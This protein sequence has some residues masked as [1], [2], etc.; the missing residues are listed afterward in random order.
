M[1]VWVNVGGVRSR[2]YLRRWWFIDTAKCCRGTVRSH[3]RVFALLRVSLRKLVNFRRW[4]VVSPTRWL[5]WRPS[6]GNNR[7]AH[8][9]ILATRPSLFRDS[10]LFSVRQ[11]YAIP[12]FT[13]IWYKEY[14]SRK[15]HRDGQTNTHISFCTKP[16]IRQ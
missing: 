1:W 15:N 7:R 3:P 5:Q 11:S 8:L 4:W 6:V 14:A 9:L 2:K 10:N 16:A 13:T 12:R